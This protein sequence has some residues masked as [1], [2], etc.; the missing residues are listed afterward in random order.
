MS[1]AVVLDL[2]VVHMHFF[3]PSLKDNNPFLYI[4]LIL[5]HPFSW[6]TYK[7]S[8]AMKALELFMNQL[9]SIIHAA[10]ATV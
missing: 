5:Y 2:F 9:I 6:S 1:F 3:E 7:Y 8:L 4:S 10:R